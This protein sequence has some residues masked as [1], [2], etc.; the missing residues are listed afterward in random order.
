MASHIQNNSSQVG[1][2]QIPLI[3]N[4]TLTQSL[5]V[6][7]HTAQILERVLIRKTQLESLIQEDLE[8]SSRLGQL[9][10]GQMSQPG[11]L[12]LESSLMQ[13]VADIE[14]QRRDVDA[15]CWRD[16]NMVIPQLLAAVDGLQAS[17]A[18]DEI[19]HR[20]RPAPPPAQL[21]KSN[22]GQTQQGGNYYA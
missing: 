21:L 20:P 15:Q 16:L 13:R 6:E 3:G 19:L 4:R 17:K 12:G 7:V 9:Q 22:Y 14:R 8:T 5:R 2:N 11:S 18:R 1:M 10:N